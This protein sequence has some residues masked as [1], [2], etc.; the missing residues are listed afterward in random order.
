[1]CCVTNLL[2]QLFRA[3]RDACRRSFVILVKRIVLLTSDRGHVWMETSCNILRIEMMFIWRTEGLLS[4]VCLCCA[5]PSHP[6]LPPSPPSSLPFSRQC[7]KRY[8]GNRYKLQSSL[9]R[10]LQTMLMQH[11]AFVF[12]L[13]L[14]LQRYLCVF[15]C[16]F[17]N[18][19][20]V[21][22]VLFAVF[23]SAHFTLLLRLVMT[24]TLINN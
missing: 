11:F 12:V 17:I 23:Q 20:F 1:M 14:I 18:C 16:L 3:I 19:M 10:H 22:L 6:F 24:H 15:S 8:L 7:N 21:Y 2:L 4:C 13:L 5:S 9:G